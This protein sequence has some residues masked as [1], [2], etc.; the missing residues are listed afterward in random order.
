MYTVTESST[1]DTFWKLS[2]GRNESCRRLVGGQNQK[3]WE[4]WRHSIPYC[5]W[6]DK[7]VSLTYCEVSYQTYIQTLLT[8]LGG[9]IGQNSALSSVKGGW[10]EGE[11][12]DFWEIA[13]SSYSRHQN[14]SDTLNCLFPS[15][16]L[17]PRT[18]YF[19]KSSSL[20]KFACRTDIFRKQI[21]WVPLHHQQQVCLSSTSW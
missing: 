2:P 5:T 3:F 21:R 7:N 19:S 16:T 4:R 10:G 1:F 15:N 6:P 18:Y 8:S 14:P 11:E 9:I 17:L 13:H 20:Q 12:R